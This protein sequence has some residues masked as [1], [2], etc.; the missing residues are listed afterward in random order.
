MRPTSS[1][2]QQWYSDRCGKH[3]GTASMLWRIPATVNKGH[4][5]GLKQSR[6]IS[7]LTTPRY[8]RPINWGGCRKTRART[9]THADTYIYIYV[10]VYKY[11]YIYIMYICMYNLLESV[12]PP[13][14]ISLKLN[15][16]CV[17]TLTLK[18]SRCPW[19]LV[20]VRQMGTLW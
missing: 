4:C 6:P 15:N 11:I 18:P 10:C 20:N 7:I 17:H 2:H 14:T 19:K 1:D 12:A 8:P 9:H 13:I 3:V 5:S 16:P